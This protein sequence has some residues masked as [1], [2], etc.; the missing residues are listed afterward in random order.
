MLRISEEQMRVFQ[1]EAERQFVE[2]TIEHIQIHHAERVEGLTAAETEERVRKAL[3][4]ARSYGLSRRDTLTAF[5]AFTFEY[6]WGFD[7]REPAHSV[8]T[9]RSIAPDDRIET[10]VERLCAD[11]DPPAGSR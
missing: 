1:A 5:V 3:D 11:M 8:L 2:R 7:E 6:G 10:L 9:D 4:R